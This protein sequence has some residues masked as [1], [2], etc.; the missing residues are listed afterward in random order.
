MTVY[1]AQVQTGTFPAVM[2]I[3]VQVEHFEAVHGQKAANY[4]FGQAGSQDDD[5]VFLVL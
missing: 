4:A 1:L 5:I 2:I 3:P